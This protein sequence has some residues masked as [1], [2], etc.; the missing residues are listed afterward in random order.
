M[1]TTTATTSRPGR[2]RLP[3]GQIVLAA[4]LLLAML[5]TVALVASNAVVLG[6]MSDEV[7][8]AE[9]QSS[10]LSNALRESLRLLQKLTELGET[11]DPADIAVQRGLF[12]RQLTVT[13]AAYPRDSPE[14][15]QLRSVEA[16]VGRFPWSR[17]PARGGHRSPLRQAG[18]VVV[19]RAE[20]RINAIR[21]EE[22]KN[23]YSATISSLEAKRR[24]QM[25]LVGLVSCVLALGVLGLVSLVRRNRSNLTRAYDAVRVSEARFRSLVQD[26]SDLTVVTDAACRVSYVSPAVEAL[27]GVTPAAILGT[28]WLDHVEPPHRAGIQ[29]AIEQLA[30]RPDSGQ[31]VQFQMR[32][33]DG[34]V[35]W[36]E[37]VCRNLTN[38]P[39]VGGIVWN[40]RDVTER[41]ALEDELTRQANHDLL[42]GLPNRLLLLRHLGDA[43]QHDSGRAAVCL[44]LIDLDDFKNVNDTLGHPAGDELLQHVSERLRACTQ[45]VDTVAR[46]GGDEFAIVVGG[47][48]EHALAVGRRVVD[49]LGRPIPVA[50][51][52]VR[53]SAS[54]GV[55]HRECTTSAEDL[56]RDADL[57]M[58]AAKRTGKG[59]VQVFEPGMRDVASRRTRLTQDLARAVESREI[60]VHYQPIV[61]LQA[62][63]TRS[64]EALARWRRPDGDLVPPDD[65]IPI[66]EESGAIHG[67]G[68]EVLHQ[69]CRS[70]A[71]WRAELPGRP[72]L[73]VTV[74]VSVHQVL[75]G[76]LVDQVVECL[77]DTALPATALTLEI[78]ESMLLEENAA[79]ADEFARLQRLGVRI[80]V[81]DFGS[82]YSSLG[83]LL[84]LKAD[85]LKID[86]T[87]LDSDTLRGG[88]LV[89][90]ISELGRTLGLTVVVEGVE[91]P[92]HLTGA[93][94]AMCDAAQGFHLSWP[95]APGDVAPFLL[96]ERQRPLSASAS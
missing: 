77:R 94:E 73:G 76:R 20:Q 6:R 70:L 86:R 3:V 75:S 37:A 8:Q 23:F 52:E 95:L 44:L 65:F 83:F 60:E 61:D 4:A 5:T 82:G 55:T 72:R 91:T 59:R 15:V 2:R 51:T 48:I 31:T 45:A 88:S 50:G 22:E 29:E 64:L 93:V 84:G 62:G 69:A 41:R 46:L 47:G 21:S 34:R 67:I 85:V 56:L 28:S 13:I 17:L 54:V 38:N 53:I 18:M 32:T 36:L 16:D 81:D 43:L 25:S 35:R 24:S 57:A 19:G 68:R 42:S 74:N 26:A 80:A 10:N 9:N 89:R 78:T 1:T 12:G 66:A 30:G 96:A 63:R 39:A 58:Y 92:E 27:L 49:A 11:T 7:Q 40:G 14:S 33:D 90:A 79:V 71:R 87:L